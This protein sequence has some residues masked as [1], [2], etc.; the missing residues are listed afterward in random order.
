MEIR[1]LDV[2]DLLVERPPYVDAIGLMGALDAL[3]GKPTI[4]FGPKGTG[5]TMG[6]EAWAA[7]HDY[8][9]VQFGCTEGTREKHLYGALGMEGGNVFFTLGCLTTAIETAN[10]LLKSGD[11]AGVM[12]RLDEVN[13][14]TPQMQ[15]GLNSFAD[16][17]RSVAVPSIGRRF[18]AGKEAKLWT[19][20]TMNPSAHGGVFDLNED[21]KSRFR[22]V[23]IPYPQ[24]DQERVILRSVLPNADV[25][26]VDQ[27]VGIA[28]ETRQGSLAYQ[29]SPRDLV[30]CLEDAGGV[31]GTPGMGLEK[32]IKLLSYHY[33]EGTDRDTFH[34]RVLGC[35]S[36]DLATVEF[37]EPPTNLAPPQR[38]GVNRRSGLR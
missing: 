22:Q 25:G 38:A 14:L 34:A 33:D 5:K 23:W 1:R 29:L 12:L 24:A 11:H 19:V 18:R 21:L 20:G 27:L 36:I 15:K 26:Q 28:T 37:L 3:Q 10:E 31:N 13:S 4:L 8:A 7:D 6:L 35:T 2:D 17:Q 16:W 32:A 30:Q 9:V